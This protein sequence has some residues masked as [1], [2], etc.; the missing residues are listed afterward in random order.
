MLL[1]DTGAFI[2]QQLLTRGTADTNFLLFVPLGNDAAVPS[3]D[4]SAGGAADDVPLVSRAGEGNEADPRDGNYDDD[5]VYDVLKMGDLNQS[6]LEIDRQLSI[7]QSAM[8]TYDL[9]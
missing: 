6:T 8:V 4:V 9:C 2:Q 7:E 1:L 3:F 5:G